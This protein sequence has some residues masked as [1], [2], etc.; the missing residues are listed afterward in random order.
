MAKLDKQIPTCYEIVLVLRRRVYN[1][2]NIVIGLKILAKEV[3]F[4]CYVLVNLQD[5]LVT[6]SLIIS[7]G[8]H[9]WEFP[10]L[11]STKYNKQ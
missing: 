8:C 2:C 3:Y 11:T 5:R 10:A 7:L 1:I 6:Y 9:G 4:Q